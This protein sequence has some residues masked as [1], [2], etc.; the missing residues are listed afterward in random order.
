MSR[1]PV[2]KGAANIKRPSG[3]SVFRSPEGATEDSRMLRAGQD[4]GP[5][6]APMVLQLA[7]LPMTRSR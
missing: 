5:G 4:D 6:M 1:L 2:L 3:T 7:P